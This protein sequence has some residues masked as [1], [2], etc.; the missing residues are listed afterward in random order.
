MRKISLVFGMLLILPFLL[1]G[2][3]NQGIDLDD[4]DI[5]AIDRFDVPAG[6]YVIQYSIEDISDLV[7]KSRSSGIIHGY[8]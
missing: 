4:I 6:T 1:M 7:K 8:Q 3:G 2:C 5:D